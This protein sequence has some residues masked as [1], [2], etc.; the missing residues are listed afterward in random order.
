LLNE[1]FVS[2]CWLFPDIYI[3]QGRVSTPLRCDGPLM[4][5]SLY[6]LCWVRGWKNFENRST[7]AEVM[8]N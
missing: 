5:S 6:D 1:T 8:G 3:S 4:I 2:D 7:F